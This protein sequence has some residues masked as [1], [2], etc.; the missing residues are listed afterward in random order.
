MSL[1]IFLSAVSNEFHGYRDLLRSDLT[2]PNVEVKAQEDFKDLGGDTL[3]KLDDYIAHCDAVIHLVGEMTGA[4]TDP[5]HEQGPLLQK[6]PDIATKLAPLGAA[7]AAGK[8][9]SYTQWE[10]WL[11][12]Y[13]GKRLLIA[14]GAPDAPRGEGFAPTDASQG[15]QAEHL[16]R[17]AAVKRFPGCVFTSADNLAKYVF[18][19][20][21]LDLLVH[22]YAEEEAHARKVAEGFIHEMAAKVAGDRSLDFEGMKQAVCNAIEIYEREIA[23]A[24]NQTNID[25]IVDA[26]LA[27][28]RTQV[29]KG[30]SGL[31]RATLRRAAEEMRREEEGR[32]ERYIA[33]VTTLYNRQRDIALATYDGEAAAEAIIFLAEAVHG[34]NAVTISQALNAEAMT[35][36]E[37][38]RDRGSN[39]HLVASIA[40]R[41]K[42]LALASSG[43][44]KGI[45]NNNLGTALRTLGAR[46]GETMRLEE[47]VLAY[48]AALEER[49]RE[50]VPLDW[51]ATQNDLGTAL[52]ALGERESETGRLEEA[53]S[54]YR[55]AL[56]ERTRERVP[57]DWAATQMN[58]GAVLSVL[59]ARESGTGRLE[60]AVLAYRA[61][62]EEWTR[63]RVPLDWAATQNNL[64][65]ALRMLAARESGTRRL[66]E[67]VSAYRAALEER[68]RERVPLDWARTKNN[69]GLA[70]SML[71]ARESGTERLKES[72]L[73]YRVALE[74]RTRER[75]PLDWAA[76]QMNLGAVLSVLGARESGT[77]RLEEAVLAYRAALEEW[78]RERVPLDWARTQ[79]NLGTTLFRLG[80]RESGTG[81]L[82]GA[83]L[84]YRAALEEW[85]RERVPLDWAMTQM[86]SRRSAFEAWRA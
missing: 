75:V 22:A 72:V 9:L 45:A 18:S 65:T 21:I 56:E 47:S 10:A 81:R 78:T 85:T 1:K 29:D 38:G 20:A 27:K 7:L 80:E 40:L 57:L 8:R 13:H 6:H 84:A 33:G 86:N 48:R 36:Y 59:G 4:E 67:A 30:Q 23:S 17:L 79:N 39:V 77:E 25:A 82:E 49:T 41:Q 15:A 11:A 3:D 5:D 50:R 51:A 14:K 44:E 26:A 12:L 46:E 73:A 74:E 19:S 34:A 62:L 37:Y 52:R 28:A 35:I 31:A 58:L 76:T 71:G 43:D 70:L 69:L 68:T 16:S 83:V 61:A 64:G 24:P 66:D 2:R 42:L 53:V 54:A 63:E 32:R 60:E 55:A